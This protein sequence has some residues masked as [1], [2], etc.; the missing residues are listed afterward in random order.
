LHILHDTLQDSQRSSVLEV[1]AQHSRRRCVRHLS[2]ERDS[3]RAKRKREQPDL[4]R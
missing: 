4:P 2:L 3:E 1:A